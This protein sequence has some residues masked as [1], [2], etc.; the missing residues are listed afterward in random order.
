MIFG[1]M[2]KIYDS[3]NLCGLISRNIFLFHITSVQSVYAK[4]FIFEK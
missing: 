1:E 4:E 2:R 3:T